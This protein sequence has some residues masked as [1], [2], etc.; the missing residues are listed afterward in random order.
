MARTAAAFRLFILA[1]GLGLSCARGSSGTPQRSTLAC[2][3]AS[4]AYLSA[5]ANSSDTVCMLWVSIL[6]TNHLL[7]TPSLN[8]M[9]TA[10]GE[11]RGMVLRTWLE[12]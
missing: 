10:V 6:P 3:S 8:A 7:V 1:P 5:K 11:M 12:C 9:M 2:A 4:R